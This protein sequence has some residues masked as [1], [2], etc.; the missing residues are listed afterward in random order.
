MVQET[1]EMR[2]LKSYIKMTIILGAIALVCSIIKN[3]VNERWAKSRD[4]VACVPA[5][6]YQSF[7]MVYHQTALN[8]VQNDAMM[9]TFVQEYINLTQNETIVDYHAQ[10]ISGKRYDDN[11]IKKS[12][13]SAIEMSLGNERALNMVRLSN[14]TDVYNRLKKGQ[15][16]WVF[17]IDDLLLFNGPQAHNGQVPVGPNSAGFGYT[18]AV[19][20]GSFQINYDQIKNPASPKLWGYKEIHLIIS[21]GVITMDTKNNP[22][23]KYGL[24][25]TW[26]NIQDID[27]NRKEEYDARNA[28][29]YLKQD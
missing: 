29:F 9:K 11:F 12:L 24:F 17:L 16:G 8:P 6:I 26:S 14:S 3:V 7:P 25:V 19:I 27:A 20:R 10:S 5:D 23:N 22:V 15:A 18:L 28:D 13:T 2:T 4:Q 21:Q 1:K